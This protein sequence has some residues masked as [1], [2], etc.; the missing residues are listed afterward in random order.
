MIYSDTIVEI[1]AAGGDEAGNLQATSSRYE[2]LPRLVVGKTET[3]CPAHS[4]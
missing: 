4:F 1:R 2:R 3:F